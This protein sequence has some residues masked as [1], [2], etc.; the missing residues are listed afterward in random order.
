MLLFISDMHL[1]EN[2]PALTRAFLHFLKTDAPQAK[3]LYL[4]GDIFNLWVGDDA[5]TDFHR[6]IAAALKQ[7]AENGTEVFI[8]HGN[9][10]FAI[11]QDFCKQAGCTLLK[12]PSVI[13]P[14][15]KP[16][17]L[18]HGDLLCTQDVGYQR[19][20]RLLRNPFINFILR[21]L[22]L[23]TRQKMAD[24]ARKVSKS[25]TVKKA[26]G[27]VDVT[28]QEVIRLMEKYQTTCLIHGHTHR[29]AVHDLQVEI[30]GKQLP[31]KRY[32]LGD[33]SDQ[34][35]WKI[36]LEKDDI[37]LSEFGFSDF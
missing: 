32:V 18:M 19:M 35:G 9:R 13:T 23:K 8:M 20:R 10:D 16:I 4:L 7:L 31:A 27:I 3:A 14:F 11:G 30:E 17:L 33:W 6:T 21:N 1:Q 34:Q 22:S 12:D 24:K 25:S 36:T 5:M 26:S 15:D 28:Q 2:R 29:P 37:Q